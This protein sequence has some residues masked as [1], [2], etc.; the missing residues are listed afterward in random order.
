MPRRERKGER[1]TVRAKTRADPAGAMPSEA[2]ARGLTL[3]VQ[4]L[5]RQRR[6]G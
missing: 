3:W 6:E 2:E 1:E 5:A 4:C